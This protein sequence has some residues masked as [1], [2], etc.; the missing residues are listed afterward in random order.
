MEPIVVI[1]G[2]VS[3]A[4]NVIVRVHDQCFTSEVFGSRRCDCREQLNESLKLIRKEAGIVIYLQQE[5]RGIGIA[6]KVAAYSLQDSL[7]VDTVDANLRLGF[8][9]ELREYNCVPDIL[10]DI[11]V[12]SIRLVTNNP[13]KIDSLTALGVVITD[14]ISLNIPAN[15]FNLSY[16]AAKRDRQQHFFPQDLTSPRPASA[17]I[18]AS[19]PATAA[20]DPLAKY[21]RAYT[22]A[23]VAANKIKVAPEGTGRAMMFKAAVRASVEANSTRRP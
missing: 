22:L 10:A 18:P 21:R 11:N 16:I 20:P 3:G 2:D 8:P 19:V 6:N 1:H 4:E 7:G 17:P 9:D 12:Q 5:G 23:Q 14:R 15:E 13:Y